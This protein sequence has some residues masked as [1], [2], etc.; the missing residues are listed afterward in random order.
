MFV[1]LLAYLETNCSLTGVDPR[2]TPKTVKHGVELR[3][4]GLQVSMDAKGFRPNP[5]DQIPQVRHYRC[6]F[7]VSLVRNRW[8]WLRNLEHVVTLERLAA[9]DI[10]H[11]AKY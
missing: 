2:R 7:W 3:Q 9:E 6:P 10:A 4:P 5:F 11:L 1:G 8:H